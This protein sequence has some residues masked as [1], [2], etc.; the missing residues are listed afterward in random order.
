VTRRQQPV[1]DCNRLSPDDIH[2]AHAQI[3]EAIIARDGALARHRM[4]THLEEVS[5]T[6][7]RRPPARPPRGEAHPAAGGEVLRE[8]PA[9]SVV[10]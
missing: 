9:A 6:G 2:A 1:F 4:M 8:E 10:S 5:A 3:A 7:P